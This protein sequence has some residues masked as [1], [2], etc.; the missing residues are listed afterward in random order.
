MSTSTVKK[1]LTNRELIERY[2][3]GYIKGY[4]D[5]TITDISQEIDIIKLKRNNWWM[6]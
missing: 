1:K 3:C 2:M 5:Y 4:V 6:V